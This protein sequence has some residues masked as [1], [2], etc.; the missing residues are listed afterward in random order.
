MTPKEQ[1]SYAAEGK[2]R[3]RREKS[4]RG[5]TGQTQFHEL[6]DAGYTGQGPPVPM[7]SSSQEEGQLRQT[8]S[9]TAA[10]ER[11]ASKLPSAVTCPHPTLRVPATVTCLRG[12]SMPQ[13]GPQFLVHNFQTAPK[14]LA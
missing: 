1:A 5:M 6:R 14:S 7:S 10:L 8:D 12:A 11:E 13:T 4:S 3:G 2:A 9:G